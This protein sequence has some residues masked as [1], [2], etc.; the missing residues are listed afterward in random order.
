VTYFPAGP[1][2]SHI[3]WPNTNGKKPSYGIAKSALL[4]Y[5]PN[6]TNIAP[7]KTFSGGVGRHISSIFVMMACHLANASNIL[8]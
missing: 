1:T 8:C 2:H 7:V 4:A 6:T 3:P 5:T